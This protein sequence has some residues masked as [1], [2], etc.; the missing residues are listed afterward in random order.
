MLIK[1][2]LS[3]IKRTITPNKSDDVKNK[4]KLDILI[5]LL[6]SIGI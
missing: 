4:I 5:E 2:V 1:L 3:K 6:F